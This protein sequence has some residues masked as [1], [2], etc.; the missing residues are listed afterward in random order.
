MILDLYNLRRDIDKW[1]RFRSICFNIINFMC[2]TISNSIYGSPCIVPNIFPHLRILH[3]KFI[4]YL[5]NQ[6]QSFNFGNLGHESHSQS[7]WD[8]DFKDNSSLDLNPY[9]FFPP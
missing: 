2:K 1:S 5:D 9:M 7:E 8:W 6:S 3:T 4:E